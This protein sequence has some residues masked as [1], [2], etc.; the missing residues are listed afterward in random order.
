MS[1][2]NALVKKSSVQA[3]FT[4]CKA[5]MFDAVE[6]VAELIECTAKVYN[7]Q[8]PHVV[9]PIGKH[10]R[11]IIDHYWA[12]QQSVIDG[13]MNYSLR[14]RDTEIERD[15]KIALAALSV[16]SDW[17][18]ESELENNDVIVESEVS[19]EN[20]SSAYVSSS[21]YRELVF[22]IGHTYHHLAYANLLAKIM[23]ISTPD[24]IGIAPATATYLRKES[25]SANA[26]LDASG[27]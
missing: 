13:Q 21:Y 19:I 11:H 5:A 16:F 26:E 15:P 7:D 23:G 14:H 4:A 2:P 25:S 27:K 12:F 9:S 10:V 6:Q 18:V 22:L 3:N 1:Q 17:L 8:P 24:H 20:E